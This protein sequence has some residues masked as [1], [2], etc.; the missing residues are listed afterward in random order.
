MPVRAESHRPQAARGRARS[1]AQ[2]DGSG[3]HPAGA[4]ATYGH[5]KSCP[6]VP[7]R[8]DFVNR[9]AVSL[10]VLWLDFQGKKVEYNVM[11]PGS[12]YSGL[13]TFTTHPW[14]LED[15][16]GTVYA[17]YVGGSATVT[18]H[19]R[20]NFTVASGV[21]S[22]NTATFKDSVKFRVMDLLKKNSAADTDTGTGTGAGGSGS[23]DS[24][25]A[26]ANAAKSKS[27]QLACKGKAK[28]HSVVG[29]LGW[30]MPKTSDTDGTEAELKLESNTK[31]DGS[32]QGCSI[33]CDKLQHD[34]WG[35]ACGHMFHGQCLARACERQME[36]PV[37]RQEIAGESDLRRLY[38]N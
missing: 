10:R 26:C 19:G 38:P 22:P 8:T 14:V 32:G 27:W 30:C 12:R 17:V 2:H 16:E 23:A 29:W 24:A 21:R 5:L 18:V 13:R 34:V 1:L 36:C 37:C 4:S 33:C 31:E 7:C 9:T 35:L 28:Q 6:G 20:D 3:R 25:H 15:P 11:A